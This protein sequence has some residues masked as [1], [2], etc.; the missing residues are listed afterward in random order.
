MTTGSCKVVA[1][2]K[3]FTDRPESY[4]RSRSKSCVFISHKNMGMVLHLF[5]PFFF[6]SHNLPQ[7]ILQTVVNKPHFFP[8]FNL[9]NILNHPNQLRKLKTV[10]MS[11]FQ[12]KSL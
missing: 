8:N 3:D 10:E 11:V 12:G 9:R 4:D 2:W 5:P 7:K 1:L 6:L